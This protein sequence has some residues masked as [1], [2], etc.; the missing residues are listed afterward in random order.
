MRYPIPPSVNYY[1]QL[2]RK[3]APFLYQFGGELKIY[4]DYEELYFETLTKLVT[5]YPKGYIVLTNFIKMETGLVKLTGYSTLIRSHRLFTS[6]EILWQWWLEEDKDEKQTAARIM[7]ALH[8]LTGSA[9]NQSAFDS[10]YSRLALWNEYRKA[11]KE[12]EIN[13]EK[14]TSV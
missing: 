4:S 10:A 12:N 9:F 8:L 7:Q 5:Y 14:T 1:N 11:R 3:C 6:D 13:N 2:V